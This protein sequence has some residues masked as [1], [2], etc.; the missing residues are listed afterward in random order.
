MRSHERFLRH[1]FSV[2]PVSQDAVRHAE[3]QGG[4]LDQP[5]LELALEIGV[6]A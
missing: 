1:F 6:H 4:R 3:R 2:R 5:D